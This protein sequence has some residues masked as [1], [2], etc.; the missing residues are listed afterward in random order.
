MSSSAT[1]GTASTRNYITSLIDDGTGFLKVAAKHIRVGQIVTSVASDTIR[2]ERG[3]DSIENNCVYDRS[4]EPGKPRE[5][6]LGNEEMKSWAKRNRG[7]QD[8][9]D[10]II[11]FPKLA[12]C[13]RLRR[14]PAAKRALA[15]LDVDEGE[16]S[17][18]QA[19][20]LRFKTDYF[21]KIRAKILLTYQER[22]MDKSLTKEYWDALPVEAIITV[23]VM[24][25][26]TAQNI[27]TSAATLAGFTRV[28][29]RLEPLCA[30]AREI[31]RR[32]KAKEIKASAPS[33]VRLSG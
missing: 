1:T 32:V 17:D 28:C 14:S 13:P 6:L 23:P 9:E 20:L 27:V 7:L 3:R 8:M 16:T 5:L 24:W 12:L 2:F 25:D 22:S 4:T 10:R 19:A 33:H 29:T 15:A 26:A 21:R 11:R 18:F 31:E 30:A